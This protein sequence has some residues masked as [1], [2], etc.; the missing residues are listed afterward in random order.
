MSTDKDASKLV[1]N[2]C[3]NQQV[4]EVDSR[5]MILINICWGFDNLDDKNKQNSTSQTNILNI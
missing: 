5:A 1:R 4:N 2:K 3:V